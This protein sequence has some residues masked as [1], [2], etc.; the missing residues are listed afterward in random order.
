MVFCYDRPKRGKAEAAN[1]KILLNTSEWLLISSYLVNR[2][3]SSLKQVSCPLLNSA[4]AGWGILGAQTHAL[5]SGDH[6]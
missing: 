3:E 5:L 2:Q 4:H 1:P 6:F